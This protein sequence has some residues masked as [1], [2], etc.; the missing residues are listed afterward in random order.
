MKKLFFIPI[1]TLLF[2]YVTAYATPVPDTGQTGDY[3][4]TFGEDSDYGPNV[5]SYTDL[6]DGIVLDNMT[7]LLWQQSTAPETYTWQQALDYVDSLNT[8]NYLGHNDWRL[9][10]IKELS[11]LVDNSIPYPGPTIDITFF[12][13]RQFLITGPLLPTGMDPTLGMWIS[14][15]AKWR[16]TVEETATLSVLCVE[17]R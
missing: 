8:E 15:A 16:H 12:P 13:K 6:G 5:H 11:T 1:F 17:I 2:L 9:P 7:G 3:S 4:S 14:T 10:T